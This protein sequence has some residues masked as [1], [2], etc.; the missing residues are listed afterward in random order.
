MRRS[1]SENAT[2]SPLLPCRKPSLD[3]LQRLV[4]HDP[5]APVWIVL[6]RL[7]WE[8]LSP[9]RPPWAAA[10]VLVSTEEAQEPEKSP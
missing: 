2:R 10:T 7:A 8:C 1:D 3:D 5:L 9:T 6:L 4:G